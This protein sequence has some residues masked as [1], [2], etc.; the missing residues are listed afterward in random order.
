MKL[1][2]KD[3]KPL[4]DKMLTEQDH[5]C[6]LC[7]DTID[8]REAVLDHDHKTGRIRRVLHR[9]CNALEGKI[10]NNMARNRLTMERLNTFA[11][12]LVT[13]MDHNYEDIVHP[14]YLDGEERLQRAK[15]RRKKKLGSIGKK[16]V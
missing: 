3:I 15:L 14:T 6:A 13:Y 10:V 9:G 16:E 11:Q 2:Y 1:K 8:P 12:N 4:R 5:R 7:E